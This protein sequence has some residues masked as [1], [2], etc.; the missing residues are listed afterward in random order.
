M[1][2][3]NTYVLLCILNKDFVK[4][5]KIIKKSCNKPLGQMDLSIKANIARMAM[6]A[7]DA[8]LCRHNIFIINL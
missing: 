1:N 8:C 2:L 6:S 4:I 7:I 3:W 5:R